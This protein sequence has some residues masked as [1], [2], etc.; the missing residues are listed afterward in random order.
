MVTLS[1]CTR[2]C[3]SVQLGL[4]GHQMVPT[5]ALI[6]KPWPGAL[7]GRFLSSVCIPSYF[8]ADFFSFSSLCEETNF[9]CMV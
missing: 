3:A 7:T 2:M 4:W 5:G 6:V 1:L 9:T 8:K